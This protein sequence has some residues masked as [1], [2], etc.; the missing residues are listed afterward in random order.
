MGLLRT[1]FVWWHDATIGT[2]AMTWWKGVPVGR[3]AFGNRYYCSKD[4]AH[5]WVI[6]DG[7]VDASRVPP[8]WHAWLHRLSDTVPVDGAAQ[9]ETGRKVWEKDHVPNLSG[10]E[11]AYYPP[12][13][14][15]AGARVATHRSYE[16]WSPA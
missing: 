12:G 13:S 14:L 15:R 6:Y 4:G 7:T 3:D 16:P 2:L 5:R 9:A 10:T 1:L 8:A 11:G